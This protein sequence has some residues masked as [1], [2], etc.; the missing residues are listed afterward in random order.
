MKGKDHSQMHDEHKSWTSDV[1]MWI[2][3]VKMWEEELE[4]LNSSMD[5]IL[6]KIK[7]HEMLINDH[8]KRLEYHKD[9]ISEHDTR[10]VMLNEGSSLDEELL[11]SHEV[12]ALRHEQLKKTHGKVKQYQRRVMVS[13]KDLR[14]TLENFENHVRNTK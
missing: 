13:V 5:I 6:D 9:V 10:M 12:G 8:N 1:N 11:E 4:A 3:D 2:H 7:D 14:G